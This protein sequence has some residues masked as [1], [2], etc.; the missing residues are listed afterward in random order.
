M[1]NFFLTDIPKAVPERKYQAA[2]QKVVEM[3]AGLREVM[4]VYQVGSVGTPGISDLDLVVV[5]RDNTRSDF[6]LH[7]RL[8]E[9]E[10]YLFIH[11]LYGIAEKHFSVATGLTGFENYKLLFGNHQVEGSR[12]VFEEDKPVLNRQVALEYLVKM[13]VNAVIQQDYGIL[14]LRSIML[15]V[16]GLNSDLL[17]LNLGHTF[18]AELIHRMLGWRKEY[19]LQQPSHRELSEW[20]VLF[21]RELRDSLNRVTE[22]KG[23]FIPEYARMQLASNISLVRSDTF[24]FSA[25]GLPLPGFPVRYMGKKYFNLQ[26]RLRRFRIFVRTMSIDEAPGV[27]VKRAAVLDDLTKYREKYLPWFYTLSSSLHL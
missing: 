17:T 18:L 5:F 13:Y 21:V 22:E 9:D 19:F 4:A 7:D 10:K 6:N 26:N 23:I 20:W 24:G 16:K 11:R 12:A 3:L 27:L 15:H 25:T 8:S 14:K 1:E 2:L